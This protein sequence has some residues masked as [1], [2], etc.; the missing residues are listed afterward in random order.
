MNKLTKDISQMMYPAA[1]LIAYTGENEYRNS[2]YFLEFRSIGKDGLMEAGKP[3]SQKFIQSLV[4]NFAVESSSVPNGEIPRNLLYVHTQKGKYVWHT[5]PC[6]KYLYFK[7]NLSI[8]N[9]EYGLPGLV[10]MVNN[11]SLNLYAYKAKRLTVNTHLYSAPFFNVNSN[12]GSVCLGNAKLKSPQNLTFQNF[13]K[14]WED[15]FFLS[16]FS[17][18]LG[19][20]P[21]KSNLVLVT[22]K[23]IQSFDNDELLPIKKMKFKDLMK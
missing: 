17:H 10:W 1:A 14:F 23:S 15:K 5:P 11:E 7:S 20:N 16:E 2:K 19:S 4:E 21:I 12:N 18:V 22:L 3:V 9:G 6:R 13:I 8:P